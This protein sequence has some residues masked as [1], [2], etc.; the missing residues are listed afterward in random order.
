MKRTILIALTTVLTG[1]AGQ[2]TQQALTG[3]VTAY[4]DVKAA[5]QNQINLMPA[6]SAG[7]KNEQAWLDSV[8]QYGDLIAV[9]ADVTAALLATPAAPTTQP[10]K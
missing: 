8:T 7:Q 1:C 2:N 4:E 10:A 3:S 5:I 9:G 6:G